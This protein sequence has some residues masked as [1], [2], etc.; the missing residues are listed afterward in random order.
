MTSLRKAASK[1]VGLFVDDPTLAIGVS[2]WI[3]VIAILG[4]APSLALI[5]PYAAALGFGAIL[6]I[7]IARGT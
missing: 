5:R 1:I 7:S 3:V 6:T 4:A 2:V